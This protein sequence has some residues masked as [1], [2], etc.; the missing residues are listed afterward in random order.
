MLLLILKSL[1]FQRSLRWTELLPFIPIFALLL[2][3]NIA[4]ASDV[5][6]L[7]LEEAIQMSLEKNLG[8]RVERFN[9]EIASQDILSE[10]GVFDPIVSLSLSE[11][12]E[13]ALSPSIV[14]SSEQ[15]SLD[16]N[17]SDRKSTRLNSSHTDISRMPSSA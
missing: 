17:I 2:S 14:T 13:R 11:S 15:R 8:L 3:C 5:V 12:Y 9:P 4:L 16:L 7:T 1:R 6:Y 10:K